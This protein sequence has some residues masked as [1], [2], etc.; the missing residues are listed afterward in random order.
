MTMAAEII[1]QEEKLR[2][3]QNDLASRAA[4]TLFE[5][6]FQAEIASKFPASV[7]PTAY[8]RSGISWPASEAAP[9][10]PFGVDHSKVEP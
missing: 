2:I 3:L 9:Q 5:R 4:A 8:P 7:T 6:Q 1:S 10:A